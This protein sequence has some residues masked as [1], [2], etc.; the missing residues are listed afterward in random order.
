MSIGKNS[1]QLFKSYLLATTIHGC[2]Y[3]ITARNWLE[4]CVWF[5][6]ILVGF[7]YSAYIINAAFEDWRAFPVETTIESISVSVKDIF[8]PAVTICP[9]VHMLLHT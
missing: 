3:L 5:V 8:H 2:Q 4:S 9:T 6:V 1:L 7:G